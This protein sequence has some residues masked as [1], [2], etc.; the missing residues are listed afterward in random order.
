VQYALEFDFGHFEGSKIQMRDGGVLRARCLVAFIV[1]GAEWCS[2]GE[3][4][5]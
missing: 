3:W 5:L 2:K 1:P 4:V